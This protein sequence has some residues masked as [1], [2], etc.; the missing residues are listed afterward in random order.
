ML[1]TPAHDEIGIHAVDATFD[2]TSFPFIIPR[3]SSAGETLVDAVPTF[4]GTAVAYEQGA[5][6]SVVHSFL[7]WYNADGS[8]LPTDNQLGT[9]GESG[10]QMNVKIL[11]AGAN[12]VDA[13][14]AHVNPD[15][16]FDIRFEELTPGGINSNAIGISGTGTPFANFPDMTRLPDGS[17]VVVWQDFD[18][19]MVKHMLSNGI[20]L[21]TTRVPD[22]AGAFLP[23]VTA[24]KDGSF[25]IAWTAEAGTEMDG[26]PRE[27]IF[28]RHFSSD[29]Q[30][31]IVPSGSLIHLASP[32]D[33]GLFQMSMKTLTD[34]RVVLAY[35]SETGDSTNV[36]DLAYRILDFS[37]PFRVDPN[38][39]VMANV[40]GSMA[41][42]TGS[43]PSSGIDIGRLGATLNAVSPAQFSEAVGGARGMSFIGGSASATPDGGSASSHAFVISALPSDSG[44]VPRITD[45]DPATDTVLL[46]HQVFAA[47]AQGPLPPDAFFAG[48]AAHDANDRIIYNPTTGVLSY[49]SSGRLQYAR[50]QILEHRQQPEPRRYPGE[51]RP[52]HH[53][54]PINRNL[55]GQLSPTNK[56][57]ARSGTIRGG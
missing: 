55:F 30:G 24:L 9:P 11:S 12:T 15:G 8:S 54:V 44:A 40:D 28:L 14:Y 21:G 17:L 25:V 43:R 19:V 42:D 33:Q 20:V 48:P 37:S 6:G 10:S 26:S 31:S 27:N 2:D 22:S 4:G 18:G 7:R 1:N 34:G 5:A 16:G 39:I 52:S 41:A 56:R 29:A 13:V 50:Q 36:T 53:C 23:K 32:G 45:F 51:Q 57:M 49:D 46:S 3:A 47:L 35:G 38:N